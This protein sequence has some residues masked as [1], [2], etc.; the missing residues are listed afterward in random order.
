MKKCLTF[1]TLYSIICCS[2]VGAHESEQESTGALSYGLK[3]LSL[4]LP[5]NQEVRLH[6]LHEIVFGMPEALR[7]VLNAETINHSLY[8]LAIQPF[9]KQRIL[10]R[11]QENGHVI[12]LDVEASEINRGPSDIRIRREGK[13]SDSTSSGLSAVALTRYA[14]QQLLSPRRLQRDLPAIRR[15]P[16]RGDID[17]S[18]VRHGSLI[19]RPLAS[20]HHG[21]LHV[22]AVELQNRTTSVVELNPEILRGAWVAAT[23]HYTRLFPN[24]HRGDRSVVYLVSGG[25]YANVLGDTL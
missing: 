12:V 16:I 10:V 23:F 21:E 17:I 13:V 4:H 8:L 3:P 11:N 9:S 6:F 22:T 1:I 20:W 7:S 14:A 15:V 19:A 5:V 2:V 24:G 18:F 25:S